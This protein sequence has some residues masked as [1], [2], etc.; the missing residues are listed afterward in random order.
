MD[1][2]KE[3]HNALHKRQAASILNKYS[4]LRKDVSYAYTL[5]DSLF[6]LPEPES[7]AECRFVLVFDCD[8]YSKLKTLERCSKNGLIQNIVR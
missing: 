5:V 3:P 4:L 1:E 6:V 2:R 8:A 7:C